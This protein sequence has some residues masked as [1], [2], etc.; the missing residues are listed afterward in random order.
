[1]II[2]DLY[3]YSKFPGRVSYDFFLYTDA[4]LEE[5]NRPEA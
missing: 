1:M 4:I 3:Q 2:N 5:N